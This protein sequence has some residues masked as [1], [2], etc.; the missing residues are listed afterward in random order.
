MSNREY[1]FNPKGQT[2]LVTGATSAPTGVQAAL[3]TDNNAGQYDCYV[4]HNSGSNL[5]FIGW[6]KDATTAQN[7][8]VVP[9][10]GTPTDTVILPAGVTAIL[11][12]SKNLYFSAATTA[13]TSD[14]YITPG[15]GL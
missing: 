10:A 9:T 12:F 14:I 4:L 13:A 3:A 2:V 5:A 11:R 6:G 7:N 1:P 8:A 15:E